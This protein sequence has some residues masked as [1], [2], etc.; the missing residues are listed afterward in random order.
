[1]KL[2]IHKIGLFI[3][4]LT[5]FTMAFSLSPQVSKAQA[6]GVP[7]G[8]RVVSSIYCSCSG[9]FLL[10][11]VGPFSGNLM[12]HIGTQAFE[13]FNLG[14]QTGM[15]ALGFYQPGGICLVDGCDYGLPAIGTITPIVGSSPIF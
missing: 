10:T 7:F 9:N 1:M 13:S 12:Y 4:A 5:V 8:G 11:F 14:H 3:F 6:L 15:W 2:L